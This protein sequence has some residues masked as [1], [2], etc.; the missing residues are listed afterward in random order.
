MTHRLANEYATPH[1]NRYGVAYRQ[2]AVPSYE[3][4]QEGLVLDCPAYKKTSTFSFRTVRKHFQYVSH[5]YKT[6]NATNLEKKSRIGLGLLLF[7]RAKRY[8]ADAFSIS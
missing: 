2:D 1:R 3:S 6:C 4:E 7:F 8:S 5:R